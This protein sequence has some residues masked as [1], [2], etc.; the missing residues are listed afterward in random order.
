MTVIDIRDT[1]Q[2]LQG[3]ISGAISIPYLSLLSNPEKYLSKKETYQIYCSSGIRSKS[4]VQKLNRLGYHCVNLEGGY[5]N[6]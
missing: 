5:K 6:Q 3:H 4:I 2:Y 1:N